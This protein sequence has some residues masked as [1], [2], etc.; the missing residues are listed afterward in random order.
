MSRL[1][2]M[3]LFITVRTVDCSFSVLFPFSYSR[4]MAFDWAMMIQLAF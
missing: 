2:T 3:I 4:M 1:D